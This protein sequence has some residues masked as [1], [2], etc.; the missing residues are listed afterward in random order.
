MRFV[1]GYKFA[2]DL[3]S[4]SCGWAVVKTDEDQNVID[5]EDMGVRIFPDGRDDKTKQPLCVS[6]RDARTSR[7]RHDRIL[8]RKEKV[9]NLLK[10]NGMMFSDN[11]EMPVWKL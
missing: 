11:D 5:F 10:E 3:G 2:F 6:R 7:V 4:T 8:E 9:L 1:M